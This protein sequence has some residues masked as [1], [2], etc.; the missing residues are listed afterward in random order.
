MGFL[1]DDEE[2]SADP[3]GNESNGGNGG[4]GDENGTGANGD[5]DPNGDDEYGE[6]EE[7]PGFLGGIPVPEDPSDLFP[8]A[9]SGDAPV[10]IELFG[11][12]KCPDTSK[13]LFEE[14]DTI[15]EE[16][17][18]TGK[19]DLKV[20][21]IAY[22]DGKS[23]YGEDGLRLARAGLAVWDHDPESFWSFVECVAINIDLEDDDWATPG[24]LEAIAKA[25]NVKDPKK[26]Y[27]AAAGDAYE[28]ELQKMIDAVTDESVEN[29][30]KVSVEGDV[31]SPIDETDELYAAIEAT[32][33][34]KS[35]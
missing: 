22:E 14:F 33:E 27:E 10:T 6:I 7:P 30:P 32:V 15:V 31:Y 23:V 19:V 13:Y 21:A 9:G 26:V 3:N 35:K 20:H 2:G 5:D 34:K 8:I 17:I 1:S 12:W 25:A 18:L 16:Y 24:R 11:D 4:N 29:V 28:K